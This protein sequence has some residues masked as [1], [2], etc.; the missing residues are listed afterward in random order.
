MKKIETKT[1]SVKKYI[2]KVRPYL[3]DI[4]NILKKSCTL[5]IQLTMRNNIAS[6]KENDEEHVMY[7]KSHKKEIKINGIADELTEKVLNLN[8]S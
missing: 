3:K 5:E 2:N 7:S 6:S 1:L 4:I 8:S